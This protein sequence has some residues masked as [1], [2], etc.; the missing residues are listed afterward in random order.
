MSTC[1][2]LDLG[3]QGSQ[4]IMLKKSPRTLIQSSHT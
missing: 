2:Q 3:T 4:P 1:N